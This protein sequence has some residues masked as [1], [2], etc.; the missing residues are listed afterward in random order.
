[1]SQT[2]QRTAWADTAFISFY[3][4]APW[5][6]PHLSVNELRRILIIL[7]IFS[8][9]MSC[10]GYYILMAAERPDGLSKKAP[11]VYKKLLK[12]TMTRKKTLYEKQ[13]KYVGNL[14]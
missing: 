4:R 8:P 3:L 11:N 1:M 13:P 2:Q 5:M 9:T 10:H 12:S 7:F 14:G 6:D